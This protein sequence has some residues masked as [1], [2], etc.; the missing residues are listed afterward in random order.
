MSRHHHLRPSWKL[1]LLL[2]LLIALPARPAPA[3]P[4]ANGASE[5]GNPATPQGT[6]PLARR[7]MYFTPPGEPEAACCINGY[8]F[9]DGQPVAGAEVDVQS[10]RG[11]TVRLTTQVYSGTNTLPSYGVS[12]S[13]PPLN[14]VAG[15]TLTVTARYSGHT[16]SVAYTVQP[17]SQTVD[18]VLARNYADDYVFDRQIGGQADEGQLND[19]AD[20][21]VDDLGRVY[22]LDAGNARV[23][24]FDQNGQVLHTWG[25]RGVLPGQFFSSSND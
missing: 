13:A 11:D 12:L 7:C 21:A 16:R 2:L 14:V 20:I 23:Q 22:V 8:V 10:Q 1:L 9:I 3:H 24:V 6:I 4:A 25:S 17:G 19:P 18:V 5:T 15:E